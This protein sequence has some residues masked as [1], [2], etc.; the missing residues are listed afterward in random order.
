MCMKDVFGIYLGSHRLL[1][2]LSIH[3]IQ[4]Y[5]ALTANSHHLQVKP[6]LIS[7]QFSDEFRIHSVFVYLNVYSISV[8]R[9]LMLLPDI[10]HVYHCTAMSVSQQLLAFFS[11][12]V[13]TLQ[14]RS[15]LSHHFLVL[16]F[17]VC[18]LPKIIDVYKIVYK[19]KNSHAIMNKIY[20]RDKHSLIAIHKRMSIVCIHTEVCM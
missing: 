20:I 10:F 5:H 1:E 12:H 15:G 2:I 16:S 18:D 17:Y 4:C 14:C 6:L 8:H 9:Y 3:F 11:L 7:E 13:I 19:A